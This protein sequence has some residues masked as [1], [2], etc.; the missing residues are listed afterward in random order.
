EMNSDAPDRQER[1]TEE[2][3]DM[4]FAAASFARKSRVDPEAALRKALVKFR[5]RFGRLEDEVRGDGK[6]FDDYSLD[7]LEEIWQRVKH[8]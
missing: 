3:G 7:D 4:L 6:K 2:I 5:D 1:L 8:L